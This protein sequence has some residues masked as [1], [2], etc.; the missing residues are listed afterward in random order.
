MELKIDVKP[1]SGNIILICMKGTIFQQNVDLLNECVDNIINKGIN[2]IIM[3]FREIS[4]IDS[5]GFGCLALLLRKVRK[6]NGDI[7]LYG[8]SSGIIQNFQILRLIKDNIN[9]SGFE[10]LNSEDEALKAF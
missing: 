6:I 9:Q 5:S 1:R 7:K 2:K 4:Y 8:I 10:I 3:N